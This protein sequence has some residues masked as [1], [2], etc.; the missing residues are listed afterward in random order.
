M[1]KQKVKIKLTPFKRSIRWE[2][3]IEIVC[4]KNHAKLE[5]KGTLKQNDILWKWIFKSSKEKEEFLK[6]GK[7]LVKTTTLGSIGY[8][9]CDKIMA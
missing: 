7:V 4:T 2:L 3:P 1:N 6:A 5:N 9:N 8:G